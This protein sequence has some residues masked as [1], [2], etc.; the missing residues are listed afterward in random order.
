MSV[1]YED[2][3][4]EPERTIAGIFDFMGIPFTS[5]HAW[6]VRKNTKLVHLLSKFH[7]RCT[8]KTIFV[9][10]K[11]N[12]LILQMH[13]NKFQD[14]PHEGVFNLPQQRWSL[15]LEKISF[16]GQGKGHRYGML[17]RHG[18]MELHCVMWHTCKI[19]CLL[20]FTAVHWDSLRLFKSL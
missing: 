13:Q 7:I 19:H 10:L 15:R 14:P 3:V 9:S 4:V 11:P 2:F 6:H 5:L 1:R 18:E 17:E 16:R 8:L 20:T 12:Y